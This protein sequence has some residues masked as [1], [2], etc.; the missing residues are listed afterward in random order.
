MTFSQLTVVSDSPVRS[1]ATSWSPGPP[2]T[3]APLGD[4]GQLWGA[5]LE[6][7]EAAARSTGG[8]DGHTRAGEGLDVPQHG[9]LADL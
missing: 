3:R 7:L 6:Q 8:V 9:P 2:L 5:V 1:H 4:V